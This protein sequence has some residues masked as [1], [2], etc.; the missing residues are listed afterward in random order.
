MIGRGA[1]IVAIL[2]A[3]ACSSPSLRFAAGV[4]VTTVFGGRAMDVYVVPGA[5]TGT[6]EAQVIMLD[7]VL[8]APVLA[9][10]AAQAIRAATGCRPDGGAV[11]GSTSV[12]TA[13]LSCPRINGRI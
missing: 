7:S 6:I 3:G 5:D 10:H 13:E 1:G 8:G 4:A 2:L 9:D 11:K 12:W